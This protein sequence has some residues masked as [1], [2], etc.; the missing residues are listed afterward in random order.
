MSTWCSIGNPWQSQ[1]GTYTALKP[2][3]ERDLTITSLRTL[4]SMVPRWM[5]P[6]AYGGP[7]CRIHSGRL[8]AA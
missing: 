4:L 5:L 7:S 3:I 6:L 1:P 2:S 8:A